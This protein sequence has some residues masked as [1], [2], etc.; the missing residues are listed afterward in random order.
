M[1]LTNVCVTF[2]WLRQVRRI[3]RSLQDVESV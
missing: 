1:Q 3:R 2:F